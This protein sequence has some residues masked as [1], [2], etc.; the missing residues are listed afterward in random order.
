M[1]ILTIMVVFFL[2]A[3]IIKIATN[4]VVSVCKPWKDLKQ[5]RLVIAFMLTGFGISGL[6]FGV[7]EAL[8]I[9]F[10]TSRPWFHYFDLTLTV[11]FLT[12][13]AQ[14]IHRLNTAWRDYNKSKEPDKRQE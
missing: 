10:E 12:G 6:N 13:G 2:L 11:L 4:N 1:D 7:L 8:N 14:A 9:P 3:T 5:Y